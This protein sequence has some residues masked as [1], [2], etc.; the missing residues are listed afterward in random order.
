MQLFRKHRALARQLIA[1]YAFHI[2]N[3]LLG[4]L[5]I[6]PLAVRAQDFRID[7]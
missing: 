3:H 1:F 4:S 2:L 7:C 5:K 6:S